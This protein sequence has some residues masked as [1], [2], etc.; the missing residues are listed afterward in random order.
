[1]VYQKCKSSVIGVCA[2]TF[3][4]QYENDS[5]HIIITRLLH[6]WCTV[7]SLFVHCCSTVVTLLL[8]SSY[9]EF[10]LT[11]P[12]PRDNYPGLFM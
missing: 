8:H 6:C 5:Y 4:Q 9:T 11:V 10:T 7:I 2:R 1:V 3:P 12:Q